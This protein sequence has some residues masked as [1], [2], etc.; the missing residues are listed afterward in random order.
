M[1]RKLRTI[2]IIAGIFIV[3][4]LVV[5]F[6]IPAN[7]F[8]P[9]IEERASAALGRRVTLG[10]LSLS[11]LSG[12]LSAED[13]SVGD[14]PSFSSSPFLTAKSLKVGVKLLPLIFSKTLNVTGVTV[15]DP[16]VTL[17]CNAARQWNYSSLGRPA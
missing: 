8:R 14:D 15:K 4:L 11:L 16:Q 10:N 5:P 1:N 12:S 3:A 6:L 9:I 13:L 17:L 7:Q 2:L